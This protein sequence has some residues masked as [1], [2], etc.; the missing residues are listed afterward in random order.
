MEDLCMKECVWE[1]GEPKHKKASRKQ[2]HELM[3]LKINDMKS[4]LSWRYILLLQGLLVW[5]ITNPLPRAL[6]RV[7]YC[8]STCIWM[9]WWISKIKP[10]AK[11]SVIFMRTILI[12]KESTKEN[13]QKLYFQLVQTLNLW[14]C[15][16]I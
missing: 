5:W 14:S 2:A 7:F 13:P 12:R 3:K 9:V 10:E 16:P 4:I 11:I 15:S 1:P 8:P 6:F